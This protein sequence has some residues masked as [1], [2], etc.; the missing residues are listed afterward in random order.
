MAAEIIAAA[1][2]APTMATRQVARLA[3]HA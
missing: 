2:P 1:D 3:L